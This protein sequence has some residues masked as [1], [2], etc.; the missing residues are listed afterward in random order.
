M[1]TH[2]YL[3]KSVDKK[4]LDEFLKEKTKSKNTFSLVALKRAYPKEKDKI[5]NYKFMGLID[6]VNIEFPDSV[7]AFVYR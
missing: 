2:I 1:L 7:Q 6:I 5:N 3:E 4:S